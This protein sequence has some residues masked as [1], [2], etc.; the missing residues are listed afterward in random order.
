LITVTLG[1]PLATR[2]GTEL[3]GGL[4]FGLKVWLCG[5]GLDGVWVQDGGSGLADVCKGRFD[6]FDDALDV[7]SFSMLETMFWTISSGVRPFS[8][9]SGLSQALSNTLSPSSVADIR[10]I[11]M[12]LATSLLENVDFVDEFFSTFLSSLLFFAE[13]SILVDLIGDDEIVTADDI[14]VVTVVVGVVSVVVDVVVA[15][16][17]NVVVGLVTLK[18]I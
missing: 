8:S 10:R 3:E 2:F 7:G 6:V 1:G 17:V 16:V 13:G 9:F 11:S 5:S 4:K 15:E 12:F 18:D 14:S